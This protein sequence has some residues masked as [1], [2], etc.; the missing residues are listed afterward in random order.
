MAEK[1]IAAL[2]D[3]KAYTIHVQYQHDAATASNYTYICNLPELSTGDFVVV[4]TRI[5][6]VAIKSEKYSDDYGDAAGNAR[7]SAQLQVDSVN[8]KSMLAGQRLS[9]ARVQLIDT[10]VDIAPDDA[11]EYSWVIAKVDLAAYSALLNRNKQITDAVQG[12]Y[13][14]NIRKSFA[15]RVLGEL[16]PEDKDNL[17]KLLG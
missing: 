3:S 15:E 13:Q 17:I 5:R 11:I 6:N 7:I 14:R 12:A 16:A 2:L 1:N 4:P 9:I 10:H 8:F